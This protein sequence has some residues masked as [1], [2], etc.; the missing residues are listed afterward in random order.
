MSRIIVQIGRK[1]HCFLMGI[2]S[3]LNLS[4]VGRMTFLHQPPPDESIGFDFTQVGRDLWAAVGS[5]DPSRTDIVHTS[6]K[7]KQLDF[8]KQLASR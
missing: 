5:Y 4:P 2:G 3:I 6:Q 7:T 8:D 1:G